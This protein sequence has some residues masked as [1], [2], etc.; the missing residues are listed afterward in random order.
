MYV[1]VADSN[2][3]LKKFFNKAE[4][5]FFANEMIFKI[6]KIYDL[7]YLLVNIILVD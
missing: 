7:L 4:G 2:I 3:V 5:I 1:A 6:H